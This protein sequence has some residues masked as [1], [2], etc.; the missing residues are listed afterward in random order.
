MEREETEAALISCLW[1]CFYE[2]E[3]SSLCPSFEEN[4]SETK[5][6]LEEI[7]VSWENHGSKVVA[8]KNFSGE[9]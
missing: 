1:I 6:W 2:L 4:L 8:A 9:E 3:A 7:S 5:E